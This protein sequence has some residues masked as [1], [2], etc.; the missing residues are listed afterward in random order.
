MSN[1]EVGFWALF[2]RK[3]QV[4]IPTMAR[5]EAGFY[6][7]IEPVSVIDP[8]DRQSIRSALLEVIRRGNPTVPTPSRAAY[9]PDPLVKHANVK[10]SSA[11]ER[12]SRRWKIAQYANGYVTATYR[13]GKYGGSEED[14][15][16]RQAFSLDE[17]VE[18]V[19]DGLLDK[20][21]GAAHRLSR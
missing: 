19:V 11:F 12:S 6:M 10:T 14:E 15:T 17:P 4:L 7:A 8:Q 13:P 5:T 20:A 3:K 1:P 18:S 9:P 21:L 16:T 2:V